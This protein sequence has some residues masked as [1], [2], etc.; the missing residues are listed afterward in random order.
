MEIKPAVYDLIL[1]QNILKSLFS[2]TFENPLKVIT[3]LQCPKIV[4]L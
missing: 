2:K 1:V 3:D 4:I